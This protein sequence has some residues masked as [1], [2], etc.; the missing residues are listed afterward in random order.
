MAGW[1][2]TGNAADPR[3]VKDAARLERQRAERRR[4]HL[5]AVMATY[6][7]RAFCWDQLELAGIYRSIWD[8]SARIHY[9]AGRQDYGHELLA[10]MIDVSEE[11]YELMEREARE[12]NK[13]DR[14]ATQAA[15]MPRA[16]QEKQS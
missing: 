12:R 13:R 14:D 10:A 6:E 7:G 11:H 4:G 1:A 2:L 9:N 3:Q 16:E 5:A 8:N 15:R